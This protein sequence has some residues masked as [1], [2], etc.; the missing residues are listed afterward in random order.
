MTSMKVNIWYDVRS[1]NTNIIQHNTTILNHLF[2]PAQNEDVLLKRVRVSESHNHN[3]D[4][5]RPTQ[6]SSNSNIYNMIQLDESS[7]SSGK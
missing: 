3:T 7:P 6:S 1:M 5:L 2:H 4:T